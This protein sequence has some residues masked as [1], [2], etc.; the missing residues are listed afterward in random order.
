MFQNT[1][2]PADAYGY[3]LWSYFK[4]ERKFEIVERDDG[5]IDAGLGGKIY[6]SEDKNWP[7]LEKKQ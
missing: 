7:P 2:K 6:F 4:G 5:Y 3:E 1:K